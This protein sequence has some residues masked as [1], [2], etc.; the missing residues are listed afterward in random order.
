MSFITATRQNIKP[1]TT[2]PY[3][4]GQDMSYDLSRVGFLARIGIRFKGT[5]TCTHASKTTF[6]K[7]PE[8]P[9]NLAKRL[10]LTL[11]NGLDIWNTSGF[12]AYLQNM[13][14]KNNYRLD[15]IISGSGVFKFGNV[16][17]STGA[18][19]DISFHLDMNVS[20]NDRDAIGL[21]LLQSGQVVATVTVENADPS[22]LMTDT[23]VTCSLTGG[24]YLTVEYFEIPRNTADWP[25]LNNV[26]QVIEDIN[27]IHSTG[28]NRFNVQRG[29]TYL[30]I[31]NAVKLNG[32]YTD[33]GIEKLG[34]KYNVSNE[35]Y[36][37]ASE[38]MQALQLMRYG[39]PLPTGVYVWDM[40]YQGVP[41]LG[42]NR[43]FIFSGNV[44]ELDQYIQIA[45]G[46]TLG[47]NNNT[48]KTIRDML[49]EV[50]T[51]N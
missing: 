12:G 42:I 15:E 19:N 27:A 17:S 28:E 50:N 24:W 26:H 1:V 31:I 36:S 9:W 22:A 34:I 45:S 23:D 38:D 35:P 6:T 33:T 16:V 49:V 30:R 20:I 11:N 14:N 7:A 39:R 3:T 41:N 5:L 48:V 44:S 32:A 4:A 25:V 8:A 18:A 10:R 29:N 37:M 51:G 13:I 40:F 21:L 43:D 2:L 46:T 47:S